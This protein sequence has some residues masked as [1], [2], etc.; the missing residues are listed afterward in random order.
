VVVDPGCAM[1]HCVLKRNYDGGGFG[2][3]GCEGIVEYV[4]N[5]ETG[6][7]VV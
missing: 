5:V 1:L 7:V 6:V 4:V 3:N 2:E